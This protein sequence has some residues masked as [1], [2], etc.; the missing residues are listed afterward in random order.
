[1]FLVFAVCARVLLVLRVGWGAGRDGVGASWIRSVRGECDKSGVDGG[2]RLFSGF[3]RLQVL[4]KVR[5]G[6]PHARVN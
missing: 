6:G 5:A 3:K 4:G 1:M 2:A